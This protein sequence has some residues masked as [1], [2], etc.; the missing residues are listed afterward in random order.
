MFIVKC[1]NC[2][3]EQQWTTGVEVGKAAIQV[4]GFSV[5]CRCGTVV[6]EEEGTVLREF[7]VPLDVH[8]IND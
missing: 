6:T 4:A 2:G 5:Y 1:T 8:E 3:R 7:V